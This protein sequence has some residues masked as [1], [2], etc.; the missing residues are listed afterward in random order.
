MFGIPVTL[1]EVII[2]ILF[3]IFVFKRMHFER[4]KVTKIDKI[5]G[6]NYKWLII[7][8]LFFSTIAIFF[9]PDKI[10]ALG[11]WKAFF[12]EPMMVFVV[13]INV[14][15]DKHQWDLIINSLGGV[16]LIVALFAIYQKITGQFIF[17]E[18]W[19]VAETRRVVSFYGFPNA[20]GLFLAPIVVLFVGRIV[21]NLQKLQK[22]LHQRRM[23]LWRKILELV[24]DVSVVV[25]GGLAIWFARSEGAIVAVVI[26]LLMLGLFF[27]RLRIFTLI[28][29]AIGVLIVA[30]VP[31]VR[32]LFIEKIS[33]G[34]FSGNIRVIV[35]Q[36]TWQMLRDHQIWG[37]GL[38]GF[39]AVIGNYHHA[40]QNFEVYLYPHNF[41]LNFWSEVGI[42]GM[43]FLVFLIIKFFYNYLQAKK[44]NK[45]WYLILMAVF[46]TILVHGI[47][48]VP[49]F[50][51]DLAV[52]WWLVV[53][54]SVV[55]FREKIEE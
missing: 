3:G 32:E 46:V 30:V 13:F 42:F 17:N 5:S 26:G 34:D 29:M 48:D 37:A 9:S 39:Q 45:E 23:H 4:F 2:V 54:M 28:M 18:V 40:I 6:S 38:A 36:E 43:L 44:I 7:G 1:L 14:I 31:Q 35:W 55:L 25:M 33:L 21:T 15:K 8:I 11:I 27:K 47:V 20:V 51:N 49:Y 41:I 52:L 50:K 22:L 19:Q 12:V 24:F 10:S 16:A 53:G